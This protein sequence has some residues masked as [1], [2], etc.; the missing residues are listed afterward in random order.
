MGNLNYPPQ[1]FFQGTEKRPIV[2]T[3]PKINQ[4]FQKYVGQ[5]GTLDLNSFNMCIKDLTQFGN[6][7]Q[8]S[9]TYL[10]EKCYEMLT[11]NNT[12]GLTCERFVQALLTVLSCQDTRSLILFNAMKR[13]PKAIILI[14]CI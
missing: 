1:H 12:I 11:N 9:Y 10:S 14:L 13:N 8:L 3:F 2:L 4:I 7:P 6:F 5:S